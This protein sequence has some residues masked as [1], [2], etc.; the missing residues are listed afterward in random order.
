MQLFVRIPDGKTITLNVDGADGV[1][2]LKQGIE[3]KEGVPLVQQRLTFGGCQLE[4]GRPLSAYNIQRES[5]VELAL[6]LVGGM[7][8][9]A[10]GKGKGKAAAE[11]GAEITPERKVQMLEAEKLALTREL[12]HYK[13]EARKAVAQKKELE[14]SIAEVKEELTTAEDVK[15]QIVKDMTRQYKSMQEN[16]LNQVNEAHETIMKLKQDLQ[17]SGQSMSASQL[18]FQAIIEQ[19]DTTIRDQNRK[20]EDMANEF[21]EMLKETLEKMRQRIEVSSV[22]WENE[23]AGRTGGPK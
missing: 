8:K 5:T 21:A 15:L 12:A 4:E 2:A 23:K 18:D 6:R 16:L 10:K 1:E 13:Q 9:K 11:D 7:A 19:K 17:S 22:T 14:G 3:R 20:M